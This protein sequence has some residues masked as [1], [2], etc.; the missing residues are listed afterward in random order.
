MTRNTFFAAMM[1][2]LMAMFAT[3]AN[4]QRHMSG[5]PGNAGREMH[6]NAR[7]GMEMRGGRDMSPRHDMGPHNMD[8]R[9]ES[10]P[11]MGNHA[12]HRW[13]NRGY[14]HGWDGRVR[15]FDDGRWGYYRD[16]AWLYYDCFYEPD[17]Y[18]A[19]PVA[20]FHTHRIHHH[21]VDPVVGAAVGVAATA[22]LIG[23]LVF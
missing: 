1:F 9:H 23:A 8:R 6:M 7:G 18:F 13:D 16:G 17:Y 2:G 15:R 22:A 19:H 20:H 11:V 21:H 3:N 10:R 12:A 14:L 4:A 5:R